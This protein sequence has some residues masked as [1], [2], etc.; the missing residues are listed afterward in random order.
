MKKVKS[1]SINPN[2]TFSKNRV[3]QIKLIEGLGVEGDSHFGKNVQHRFLAKKNPNQDNLRQVH[4]IHF[5]LL[6]ELN[7]KGFKVLE[8]D[9]G[10]NI[11]TFGIDLLSLPT[12]TI[13]KIGNAVKIKITGLRNPCLQLDNFQKGLLKAVVEKDVK[14]NVIRKCGVM[15]IVEKGGQIK[16]DDEIELI[17]PNE[18]YEKLVCV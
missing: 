8:G 3:N 10:E 17:Y 12:N 7:G 13:L 5:E 6:E 11:T 2:H 4:L 14:G 15:G 16:V 9:L 18:P 1:V